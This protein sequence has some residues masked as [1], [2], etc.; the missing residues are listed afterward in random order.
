MGTSTAVANGNGKGGGLS[1][2]LTSEKAQARIAPFLPEGVKYDRVVAAAQ[3]AAANNPDIAK[4]DPA[5]IVMAVAKAM[6][7]GLEIGETVHLVPFGRTLTAVADY[8]GL[9][10]LMI[11]S[12]CVR[13]VEAHCVYEH[14]GFEYV[15]GSEA[16]LWHQPVSDRKARG[17][18]K[19]AYVLLHLPFGVRA[20]D[21]M[22]I[23][24]IDEIRQ[25][26][27]KQWKK[28][29]VPAWYAK[30]T[31]VRQVSKLVPKDPRLAKAFAV[32]EQDVA[33]EFGGMPAIA[34]A[35]DDEIPG[36]PAR[37]QLASGEVREMGP[38]WEEDQGSLLGEDEQHP[39]FQMD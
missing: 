29:P 37:A 2:L 34:P 28:G 31:V 12:R 7:W 32:L 25:K 19:G 35:D 24:D 38:E 15:Q 18:L 33:E 21:Y 16:R 10:Q 1:G 27:S 22:S 36:A 26:Y 5:S 13:H 14:D 30:K 17:A 11:A 23:E 8:K 9:A 6:Q 20:F 3:L 39:P 4:C